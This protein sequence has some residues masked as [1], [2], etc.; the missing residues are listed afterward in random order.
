MRILKDKYGRKWLEKYN[1]YILLDI[2]HLGIL[3]KKKDEKTIINT[4]P[5]V[6]AKQCI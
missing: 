2:N 5:A 1:T 4:D 3:Y 6:C